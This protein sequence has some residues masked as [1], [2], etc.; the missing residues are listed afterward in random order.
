MPPSLRLSA[1]LAHELE[2]RG[3]CAY[4]NQRNGR[5]PCTYEQLLP[6]ARKVLKQRFSHTPEF[7][8][9]PRED[10]SYVSMVWFTGTMCTIRAGSTMVEALGLALT[11]TLPNQST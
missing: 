9:T 11:E 2:Q 8:V 4:R 3:V 10:G 7:S 5:V 6:S 1:N